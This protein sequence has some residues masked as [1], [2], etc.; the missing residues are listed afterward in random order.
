[1]RA[2]SSFSFDDGT[3]NLGCFALC[4]LRMRVK[5]S[6]TGSV[7]LIVTLLYFLHSPVCLHHPARSIPAPRG[8]SFFAMTGWTQEPA[9]ASFIPDCT[10][11]AALSSHFAR[12][13]PALARCSRFGLPTGLGNTGNL[14]PQGQC[15]EAQAAQAELAQERARAAA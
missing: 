9:A 5:K 15:T 7:K 14:A 11:S 3:S 12:A 1:M 2:I 13:D 4:A 6:A 10:A 8:P